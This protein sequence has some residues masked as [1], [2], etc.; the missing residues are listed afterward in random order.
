LSD[1]NLRTAAGLADLAADRGRGA[2]DLAVSW[3][4]TRPAVASVITG[5]TRPEQVVANVAAADW[6]L[7]PDDLQAVEDVLR[8]TGDGPS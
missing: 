6:A 2:V 8:A 7:S 3:L 1:C 4:L 5:A